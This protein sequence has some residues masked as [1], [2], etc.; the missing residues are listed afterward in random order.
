MALANFEGFLVACIKF[1]VKLIQV[2][3]SCL[4]MVFLATLTV[5]LVICKSPNGRRVTE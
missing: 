4:F 1:V 5:P 3:K 2:V